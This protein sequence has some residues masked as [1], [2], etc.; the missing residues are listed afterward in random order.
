MAILHFHIIENIAYFNMTPIYSDTHVK[1]FLIK[2]FTEFTLFHPILIAQSFND[3]VIGNF[4]GD[5]LF[6]QLYY[7]NTGVNIGMIR[8]RRLHCE[9][10]VC[11]EVDVCLRFIINYEFFKE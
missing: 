3:E 10:F 1:Y 11:N 4:I 2:Y 9:H 6:V 7:I 5:T 8:N